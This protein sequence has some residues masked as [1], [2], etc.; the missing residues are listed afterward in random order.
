MNKTIKIIVP[1]IVGVVVGRQMKQS[2]KLDPEKGR[3]VNSIDDKAVKGLY[4]D[5][6]KYTTTIS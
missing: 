1:F 5:L 3:V 2:I 6:R 4:E